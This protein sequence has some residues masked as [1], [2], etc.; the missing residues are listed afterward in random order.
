MK[1]I[2]VPSSNVSKA[3]AFTKPANL[4]GK[5]PF[6]LSARRRFNRELTMI[7]LKRFRVD[8]R[9][10]SVNVYKRQYM[11]MDCE[12]GFSLVN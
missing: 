6:L 7:V 5:L 8:E 11:L 9:S 1:H 10:T 3:I 12:P 2:A 4:F